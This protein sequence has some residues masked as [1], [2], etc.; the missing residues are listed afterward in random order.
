VASPQVP[1]ERSSR[2]QQRQRQRRRAGRRQQHPEARWRGLPGVC[3]ALW[4]QGP[5]HALA[6]TGPGPQLARDVVSAHACA[7]AGE[8]RAGAG[9]SAAAALTGAGPPTSAAQASSAHSACWR[10]TAA[11]RC[12]CWPR[13]A[14]CKHRAFV[15]RSFAR[16][17]DEAKYAFFSDDLPQAEAAR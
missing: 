2:R 10:T 1:A 14:P 15:G 12:C 3:A 5:R 11:A 17:V 13:P 6:Q 16:S 7:C 9:A 8:G 4:Q